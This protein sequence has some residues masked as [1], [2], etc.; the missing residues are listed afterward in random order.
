MKSLDERT[1][2]TYTKLVSLQDASL[3][4][5]KV[6]PAMLAAPLINE[7]QAA[8]ILAEKA[9]V[10]V[11][12]MKQIIEETN[13][14]SGNLGRD[15]A[16]KYLA[17]EFGVPLTAI[18]QAKNPPATVDMETPNDDTVLTKRIKNATE[19][20]NKTVEKRQNVKINVGG[21][22]IGTSVVGE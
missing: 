16:I 18:T 3:G 4:E 2:T 12:F 11:E 19:I 21:K 9:D 13:R 17:T 6:T 10:K 1:R 14:E 7:V 22:T 20:V 15:V 5:E 8:T